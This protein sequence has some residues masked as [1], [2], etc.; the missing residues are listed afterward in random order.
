MTPNLEAL[1]AELEEA[2]GKSTQ[3]EWKAYRAD[4]APLVAVVR[5]DRG[6]V[7]HVY[8]TGFNEDAIALSHNSTAALIAI[9]RRL[10]EALETVQL[11]CEDMEHD[12]ASIIITC[13]ARAYTAL[14][15]A[16]RLAGEVK[17]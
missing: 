1:L 9:I 4:A 12:Q 8:D 2:H 15:D 5:S 16:E 13:G 6:V 17:R 14:A 10:G 7:A 11:D 3:G